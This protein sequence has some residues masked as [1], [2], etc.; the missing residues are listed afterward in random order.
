MSH[1]IR[2]PLTSIIG[3]AEIL[4]E[5]ADERHRRMS[6]LIHRAGSRLM[7]TLDSVLHLSRLEAGMSRLD[8]TEIDVGS[9]IAETVALLQP[10]AEEDE[11]ALHTDLP[12][13][14]VAA[15]VD[16]A[17]LHRILDNIVSNALK[18]TE[19]GGR[20][21]VSLRGEDDTVIITVED[22]GVGIDPEFMPELFDAFKQEQTGVSRTYEGSGL[23]LTVVRRLVDLHQGDIEVESTKN[24]GSRFTITLSR[25]PPSS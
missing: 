4:E 7:E 8:R 16:P 10:R 15:E 13:E 24:E 6:Q 5:E 21:D 11:I 14:T 1:E 25:T 23:G 19:A 9:E 18:F 20:V 2:T 22:T 3:F 12:E 17:A